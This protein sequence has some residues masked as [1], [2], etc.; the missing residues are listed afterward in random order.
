MRETRE[1]RAETF[2]KVKLK[3]NSTPRAEKDVKYVKRL[4]KFKDGSTC[5]VISPRV[6]DEQGNSETVQLY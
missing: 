6:N 2:G 1:E 5:L 4:Y 3:S